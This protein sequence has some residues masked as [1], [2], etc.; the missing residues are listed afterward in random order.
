LSR[1]RGYRG[2]VLRPVCGL[3]LLAVSLVGVFS[4]DRLMKSEAYAAWGLAGF[5]L[6]AAGLLLFSS[7][8]LFLLGDLD[9]RI[10][11]SRGGRARKR[12]R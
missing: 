7:S 10:E 8:L 2:R 1:M 11:A 12:D 6:F 9:R 5:L 3:F 4:G